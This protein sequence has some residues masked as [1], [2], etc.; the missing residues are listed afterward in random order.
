MQAIQKMAHRLSII[1]SERIAEE[2]NKSI[3]ADQPYAGFIW[4]LESNLLKEFLPEMVALEGVEKR[5]GH[6]HKDNFIHTLEVLDNEA[7]VR[8]NLKL[9]WDA[10]LHNIEQP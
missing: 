10:I 5:N 9:R 6:Y 7:E 4:Y 1:S 2:L 3:M 8:D